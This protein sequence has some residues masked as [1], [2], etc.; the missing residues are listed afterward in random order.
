MVGDLIRWGSII[1][2]HWDHGTLNYP[3]PKW[4]DLNDVRFIDPDPDYSKGKQL[5]KPQCNSFS[6]STL[7]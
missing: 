3:Y 5:K 2:D 4:I 7:K 1:Q 6:H